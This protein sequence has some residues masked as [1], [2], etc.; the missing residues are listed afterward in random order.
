MTFQSINIGFAIHEYF[1]GGLSNEPRSCTDDDDRD[2]VVV[3]NARNNPRSFHQSWITG[4]EK[5]KYIAPPGGCPDNLFKTEVSS[6]VQHLTGYVSIRPTRADSKGLPV[7]TG[8]VEV[9][10][11]DNLTLTRIFCFSLMFPVSLWYFSSACV[12]CLV[13]VD[14]N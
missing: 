6:N 11:Q 10:T 12:I 3:T 4:E 13:R 7:Y 5:I 9:T 1:T 2:A 8:Q 14:L